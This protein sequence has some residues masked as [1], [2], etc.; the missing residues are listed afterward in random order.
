MFA[1]KLNVMLLQVVW[2]LVLP[3]SAFG[4]FGAGGQPAD[5]V[6]FVAFAGGG[7]FLVGAGYDKIR[8]WSLQPS[9]LVRTITTEH[10]IGFVAAAP[11]G[12]LLAVGCDRGIFLWDIET[13]ELSKRLPVPKGSRSRGIAVSPD[14][15][16]LASVH[17]QGDSDV[18]EA[19]ATIRIWDV[20]RGVETRSFVQAPGTHINAIAFAPDGA[21]IAVG[22]VHD[23]VTRSEWTEIRLIGTGCGQPERTLGRTK[24]A[25]RDLVFSPDGRLLASAGGRYTSGFLP[26]TV[27]EVSLWSVSDGKRQWWAEDPHQSLVRPVFSPDGKWIAGISWTGSSSPDGNEIVIRDVDTGRIHSHG[28]IRTH[29]HLDKVSGHSPGRIAYSPDPSLL[30]ACS[31]QRLVILD[32]GTLAVRETL[33]PLPA[34]AD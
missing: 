26:T 31:G 2:I 3:S 28:R 23:W 24:T 33:W 18:T 25:V 21:A 7:T 27:E 11:E 1:G 30:A 9:K 15:R 17:Q 13:G 14:G 29:N 10:A 6:D 12:T 4:Q 32:T 34:E 22:I 20:D 5:R 8:I 19:I 16:H